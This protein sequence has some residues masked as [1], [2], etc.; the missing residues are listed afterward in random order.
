MERQ[1]E[2]YPS[3]RIK[4]DH[5]GRAYY[6]SGLYAFDINYVLH[7]STGLIMWNGVQALYADGKVAWQGN[8]AYHQNGSHAFNPPSFGGGSIPTFFKEDG[9]TIIKNIESIELPLG[10]GIR[11]ECGSFGSRIF[12]FGKQILTRSEINAG[13]HL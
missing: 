8:Y 9:I 3:G 11:F 10:K 5:L 13:K 12:V 2:N 7:D 4:W 6:E 1:I